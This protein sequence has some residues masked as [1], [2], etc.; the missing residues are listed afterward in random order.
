MP[1]PRRCSRKAMFTETGVVSKWYKVDRCSL[2]TIMLQRECLQISFLSA[3]AARPNSSNSGNAVAQFN[4]SHLMVPLH[5]H[6][7]PGLPLRRRTMWA[8]ARHV[9]VTLDMPPLSVSQGTRVTHETTCD[10]AQLY[11]LRMGVQG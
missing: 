1:A 3:S 7:Y 8:G 10:D 11:Q 4:G 9:P 6:Y 2:S 5:C